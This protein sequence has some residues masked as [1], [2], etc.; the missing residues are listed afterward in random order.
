MWHP[1]TD[2]QSKIAN[3]EMERYLRSYVNQFQDDCVGNLSIAELSSNANT[4]ATTKVSLF[5]VSHGYMPKMSFDPV[6][7]MALSTRKQL[8]NTKAKPIANYMQEV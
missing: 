4:L 8:A 2:G 1:K 3:Q 5:L 7:L 6:D